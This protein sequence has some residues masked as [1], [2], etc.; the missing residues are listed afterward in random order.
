M[1]VPY[2]QMQRR[3][4]AQKLVFGSPLGQALEAHLPRA[5]ASWMLP[6]ILAHQLGMR[7]RVIGSWISQESHDATYR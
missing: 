7:S 6:D 5:R 2:T 4:T 3:A 1:S